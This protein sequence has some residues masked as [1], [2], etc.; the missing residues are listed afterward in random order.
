MA[1]TAVYRPPQVRRQEAEAKTASSKK[2]SARST[3]G[4][5]PATKVLPVAPAP[6]GAKASEVKVPDPNAW[7]D[8]VPPAERVAA[9]PIAVN[10][11]A[12]IVLVPVEPPATV[13]VPV[14]IEPQVAAISDMT[15]AEKVGFANNLPD[16]PDGNDQAGDIAPRAN[17]V[18]P[19]HL[20]GT[21]RRGRLC[22]N[23]HATAGAPP[24]I[25]DRAIDDGRKFVIPQPFE[26][27]KPLRVDFNP[28]PQTRK[29]A[30]QRYQVHLI[31]DNSYPTSHP[32]ARIERRLARDWLVSHIISEYPETQTILDFRGDARWWAAKATQN[33]NWPAWYVSFPVIRP[34]DSL[35]VHK[36]NSAPVGH[37]CT[38]NW[39]N[40]EV[41]TPP[42][43]DHIPV[44]GV[45]MTVHSLAY[46]CPLDVL[47]LVRASEDKVFFAATVMLPHPIGSLCGGE[48]QYKVL[49]NGR[50]I[51]TVGDETYD[52][53]AHAWVNAMSIDVDFLVETAGV[54][55]NHQSTLAWKII[56]RIGDTVIL[57]FRES[58]IAASKPARAVNPNSLTDNN[59]WGKT[60]HVTSNPGK[61]AGFL[62]HVEAHEVYSY[63]PYLSFYKGEG[64]AYVPK[65]LVSSLT[66]Y[67]ANR[68]RNKDTWDMLVSRARSLAGS[69]TIPSVYI[70][71]AI[72][73]AC[74]IAFNSHIASEVDM[75]LSN[76]PF[77]GAKIVGLIRPF[78]P[79]WMLHTYLHK[80]NFDATV[81]PINPRYV[82]AGVFLLAL[83]VY[84]SRRD[85]V[86]H[87]VK[88]LKTHD[89]VQN[90]VDRYYG[91]YSG[92]NWAVGSVPT[93]LRDS[94]VGV[95]LSWLLKP[96]AAVA[97]S[98]S[99]VDLV[100]R[101]VA[102]EVIKRLHP[103]VTPHLSG[104]ESL[105]SGES[106]Q[107]AA[108]RM[109]SHTALAMLP[110][111]LAIVLH[112]AHNTGT[113]NRFIAVANLLTQA[114]QITE[115][116]ARL[117]QPVACTIDRLQVPALP[118]FTTGFA[119]LLDGIADAAERFA[120]GPRL[121]SPWWAIFLIGLT[122][123]FARRHQRVLTQ[124]DCDNLVTHHRSAPT[125]TTHTATGPL[126]LPPVQSDLPAPEI[127]PK[128]K[129]MIVENRPRLGRP[130]RLAGWAVPEC[131]PV[132]YASDTEGE[133]LAVTIRNL[134]PLRPIDV[135][136]Y[137]DHVDIMRQLFSHLPYTKM[138]FDEWN[139]HFPSATL[140]KANLQAYLD[141]Q[142]LLHPRGYSRVKA[143]SK[144][145]LLP[146]CIGQNFNMKCKRLIQGF[147]PAFNVL[148]GPPIYSFSKTVAATY[149]HTTRLCIANGTSAEQ[150]GQWF[151]SA[152]CDALSDDDW[153]DTLDLPTYDSND[154]TIALRDK[155]LRTIIGKHR[156]DHPVVPDFF[157]CR[158]TILA[159]DFSNFD[160]SQG[161]ELG[162]AECQV[163]SDV[164]FPDHVVNTEV[165]LWKHTS[166]V[167]A[168]GVKYACTGRRKSGH[169]ATSLGNSMLTAAFFV[170]VFSKYNVRNWYLMV[171]G[172]DSLAVVHQDVSHI[173]WS[174]E[175]D[176]LGLALKMSIPTPIAAEFCSSRFWPTKTGLLL[177][178]KPFRVLAK[179]GWTLCDTNDLVGHI[180]GVVEGMRHSID[181]MP[182]L[183]SLVAV[184]DRS[185]GRA[186]EHDTRKILATTHHDACD[187][188]WTMFEV[189]Y[190]VTREQVMALESQIERCQLPVVVSATFM[191]S[192]CALDAGKDFQTRV[193]FDNG[194]APVP[195][196]EA[197]DTFPNPFQQP[198]L[199]IE[200]ATIHLVITF[201]HQA[202]FDPAI[203]TTC[204]AMPKH[205]YKTAGRT[206]RL[207]RRP[208]N[209]G[210]RRVNRVRAQP[211]P[212]MVPQPAR[213]LR[214]KQAP[215]KPQQP[216]RAVNSEVK[217]DAREDPAAL[218]ALRSMLSP[219]LGPAR[220]P[221]A[222]ATG[223]AVFQSKILVE[224]PWRL[225][226]SNPGRYYCGLYAT[227]LLND[228]YATLTSVAGGAFTWTYFDDVNYAYA[229]ANFV[230]FRATGG[231]LRFAN[232]A[233]A[234]TS[235]GVALF[236]NV[237]NN[238]VTGTSPPPT[239]TNL[240]AD[241]RL[242]MV[243]LNDPSLTKDT[244]A[245]W[246]PSDETA[247]Q[248]HVVSDTLAPTGTDNFNQTALC[249]VAW[250]DY[251]GGS[252]SPTNVLCNQ[253]WNYEGLP[254]PTTVQP[255]DLRVAV[256]DESAM[257]RV[258]S[259]VRNVPVS[260]GN[261]DTPAQGTEGWV[262]AA[263]RW[264]AR[265]APAIHGAE[266]I[267]R[268][269]AGAMW[270]GSA[271]ETRDVYHFLGDYVHAATK[272]L[273]IADDCEALLSKY[274]TS[275]N[276]MEFIVPRLLAVGA[277]RRRISDIVT[278]LE[279]QLSLATPPAWPDDEDDSKSTAST[280][281]PT[282]TKTPKR[283]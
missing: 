54:D 41:E 12:P 56:H 151:E 167:T 164:G 243:Q 1:S 226:S 203:N 45:A 237:S 91:V 225:D 240:A 43:C 49:L 265:V 75:M 199:T 183:R 106:F 146:H 88:Y 247:L 24:G 233:T 130:A 122:A 231:I 277:D 175:G 206:G 173:P 178:P 104:L 198:A 142:T 50:S 245:V 246:V 163:Y 32:L 239:V 216:R 136:T 86:H 15:T 77:F 14:A 177:A 208:P 222:Y 8:Y 202:S 241:V 98:F 176:A 215:P 236:G 85:L 121:S 148:Q 27:L 158:A 201:C 70:A 5:T 229:L 93:R 220:L 165:E 144:N 48:I 224:L 252:V 269:V 161:S 60:D 271:D 64:V 282:R 125:M 184:V 171:L 111:P 180:K 44:F 157:N 156:G 132:N 192:C 11:P 115:G 55:H 120:T 108:Y 259:H 28:T 51:V 80:F 262:R 232:T 211:Q 166:G 107:A 159:G 214:V 39:L 235:G 76:L 278:R 266:A 187:E 134:N 16:V 155:A 147:Y 9:V 221:D 63:G 47:R 66:L 20:R 145:E 21:C 25:V 19:Y 234:L 258:L 210:G 139:S 110:L 154:P 79:D 35:E 52:E 126:S 260:V 281:L 53:P 131:L 23:S 84:R 195:C 196:G 33:V 82:I 138:S 34:D 200:F 65:S 38:C 218:H 133:F 251:V 42:L 2:T 207:G 274:G 124:A 149:N 169:P 37:A 118:E 101:V 87:A 71:D 102:E 182:I 30:E 127:D 141:A 186:H 191:V 143:F 113:L 61:S 18:C 263:R 26:G 261:S 189:L 168:H 29:M 116:F 40:N 249:F 257:G 255:L 209:Q 135:D 81:F 72:I 59:Y 238:G 74:Y 268:V 228:K 153:D 244:Q 283:G 83:V 94:I 6:A 100:V 172:D 73:P 4:K 68:P 17:R 150:V 230:K 128:A 193:T 13:S 137:W 10:A 223:T 67:V 170:R 194:V 92:V 185:R 36:I 267:Y 22:R 275:R 190:G 256:G 272:S 280:V 78:I 7:V 179:T 99:K 114:T 197:A 103:L 276:V 205:G 3:A 89:T 129:V 227:P 181:W 58:T 112:F 253:V 123:Y 95:G 264:L 279:A 119:G 31:P 273:K 248:F 204:C 57:E 109:A 174:L 152:L 213:G 162:F 254:Y 212:A 219:E 97:A 96:I 90:D 242:S 69:T 62:H 117:W 160:G 250:F 217:R 270:S 46:L 188:T 140:R 105:L